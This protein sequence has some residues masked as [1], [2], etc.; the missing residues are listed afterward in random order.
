MPQPQQKLTHISDLDVTLTLTSKSNQFICTFN[1]I[2]NQKS[3]VKT[4]VHRFVTYR[5]SRTHARTEA[6]ADGQ[7]ENIMP[8]SD[9]HIGGRRHKK[10]SELEHFAQN[11]PL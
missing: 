6:S 11:L 3:L 8:P 10:A 4:S 2:I 9:T 5:A 1:Y 7:P